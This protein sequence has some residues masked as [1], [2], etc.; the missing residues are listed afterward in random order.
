MMKLICIL[1]SN[2]FI[3]LAFSQ[4]TEITGV[5]SDSSGNAV[6]NVSIKERATKNGTTTDK[7]GFFKLSTTPGAPLEVSMV[8]YRQ[9][10]VSAAPNLSVTLNP[11]STSLTEVIVSAMG[12]RREKK[13]F[14]YAVSTVNAKDIEQR[15]E[16]DLGRILTGKAPGLNILN[17]SGLSGSGTQIVIRG[18]STITGGDVSPLF[19]I[20]GVPFDAGTNTLT[21]SGTGFY[22]GNQ[23]SSRF[24]DIDPNNIESVNILKGLSAT[25]LYGEFG[26]NGVILI[27]TKNGSGRKINK[28]A[29]VTLTQSFFTNKV[30]NLPDYTDKY[31]GGFNLAPSP[32]FSNWGAEFKNTPD[33]F[34]HPYDRAAVTGALPQYKGAKYAYKPYNSVEDFFRTGLVQNTSVNVNGGGQNASYNASYSYLSDEGFTPGNNL[35]KNNFG[36]GGNAAL[37]NKL[38]LS[39]NFNYITTDFNT[40]S[41][42]SSGGSSTDAGVSIFGDLIYTPRSI[43]L[44]GWDYQNPADGSSVYYRANNGIQNPRWTAENAKSHQQVK[45]FFGSTQMKYEFF[46]GF[47]ATYR[48]GLDNYA[49]RQALTVNRGGV[50]GG[51]KFISGLYRTTDATNTITD[52]TFLLSYNKSISANWNISADGGV[53]YR[54]DK[55]LQEGGLSTGQ[56]V[57]GLFDHSNFINHDVLAEDGVADLDYVSERKS[58]GVFAQSTVGYKDFLYLNI[59]GRNSWSSTLEKN[60]RSLFYPN[61]SLSFI[62]T[63]VIQSLKGSSVLSYLK[64]R[65]S[66]A[67]SARFPS[68]YGTRTGLSV[69]TNAFVTLTGN[70]VNVNKIPNTLANPDLKPE[71]IKEYEAGVEGRF[72]NN[73]IT[74]DL[75]GYFRTSTD[76]IL[77]RQLDPSSGYDFVTVNAGSVDNKGIELALGYNVVRGK[78]W[79]W[80]LDGNFTLNR[81]KVHDMPDYIKQITLNGFSNLGLYAL[82]N[83]PLGVIQG[84]TMQRDTKSGLP[85]VNERGLLIATTD[86]SIIGDPNPDYK[87]TGI[88]T[89]SYKSLSFRMQWD[90]TKG[91]DIYSTTVRALLARGV[92]KDLDFDRSLPIII[93]NTVKQDGTPNDIQNSA[94]NIYFESLGFGPNE[95]SVYD[96]TVVRLREVSLSYAIPAGVLKKT[97]FGAASINLSGNNLWYHAPNFPKYTNFDPETTSLA[98]GAV[99]GFE[100]LTGPSSRRLGVSLRVTF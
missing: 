84:S 91:G 11:V 59:G 60:N 28:K 32:A 9:V 85:V 74:L 97:P 16:G 66:Y 61:L 70:A 45:R 69:G 31:G 81:N 33:S 98:G 3:C 4:K 25:T 18:I 71:L 24:L 82:N 65:A 34:A 10:V 21:N 37:S 8:G 36:L 54:H 75:T 12:I 55:Y 39:G 57:F 26:R 2:L 49:E 20:D 96:A 38:S 72:L 80:Q 40:P 48:I 89:L 62:P 100:R 93:P 7:N 67:T 53:N 30:S 90:F 1:I 95:V 76:Q 92:T 78:A 35:L 77:F 94:T 42:G 88:S 27:T 13:A 68:P 56:L 41:I 29:E 51:P 5:V 46:K 22:F 43:D 64:L 83:Q 14:G 23:T 47:T 58:L 17:T 19:I 15:S 73:R 87:L 99:A 63:S 79:R 86:I 44:M 52:H 50:S 6:A